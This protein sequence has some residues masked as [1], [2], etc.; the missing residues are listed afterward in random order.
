MQHTECFDIHTHQTEIFQVE[1]RPV[2]VAAT[3]TDITSNAGFLAFG[4][5]DRKLQMISAVSSCFTDAENLRRKS[6]KCEAKF[7]HSLKDLLAQ[8][9]FQIGLGYEDGLDANDWRRDSA[10]KLAVGKDHALGSQPMMSRLENLVSSKDLYRAWR[11]MVKLYC[12]K[13]HREGAPVVMHIDSTNDPVHGQLG[14]FNGYYYEHCFHPLLV[15]EEASDFPLAIMLRDGKA[16][17]AMHTKSMLKRL[18]RWLREDIP[19]VS[20]V[21]KGDCAFGVADII[22]W[23]DEQNVDFIFGVGGNNCLLAKV[24]ALQDEVLA[25]YEQDKKPLQRFMTVQYAAGTWDRERSVVAKVEHTALGMNIRFVVSSMMSDDP[26]K[27]YQ[28]FQ[29]RACRI[30]AC[31]EQLKNGLRFD[32]TACHKIRP[33]QMRYLEAAM[34]LVLHLKIKEIAKKIL[35]E[36]P[37]VQTLIQKFLKVAAM[38]TQSVRRYFVELSLADPHSRL[39][40]AILQ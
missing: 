7:K 35:P 40:I 32:K 14:L 20:I 37:T 3:R 25:A 16:S 22:N 24:K 23:L 8:R 17:S 31:I 38:V 28:S 4:K 5:I 13:F 2:I 6:A 21:I 19:G 15:T 1:S 36:M 33:N 27:L 26:E 39:L 29:R 12:E 34:A 9:V 30:E 18:I 11:R 10:L